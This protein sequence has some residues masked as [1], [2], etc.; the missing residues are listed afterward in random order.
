MGWGVSAA[1]NRVISPAAPLAAAREQASS[2]PSRTDMAA[3]GQ[4]KIA[5][6]N[7]LVG[8]RPV[9]PTSGKPNFTQP[10]SIPPAMALVDPRGPVE[11][12]DMP[13][14]DGFF[15]GT[16]TSAVQVEGGNIDND[17]TRW[18]KTHKGW[19]APNPGLDHWNRLEQDYAHLQGN[20]HNAHGFT[21]DWA[22]IEPKPGVYDRA[23][24]EHY[25]QELAICRKDGMEPMVTLMQY[26][27]PPWLAAKGGVLAPE[28]PK[29]FAEF[30]R[31]CAEEFGP[32]VTW[33]NTMNEPNT[34][35]AA[36]YLGGIW[37]PGKQNPLTYLRS[38][39]AQLRMHA[40]AA[41]ELHK[42]AKEHNR[43]AKVGIVFIDDKMYSASKWNPLDRIVTKLYDWLA[44][45]AFLDALAGG[46]TVGIFGLGDKIP[47]LKG[48][49]DYFG[50]NFYGRGFGKFDTKGSR[51]PITT[52][53]NP[54]HKGPEP[55]MD[56]DGMYE[57]LLASYNQFHVP[58]MITE[59]GVDVPEPDKENKRGRAIVDTLAAM[60][61]AKADGVPVLG[62]LHWTDWDSPEWADGWTQHYGLFG[63]DPQT[64][65]RWDKPAAATFE[66]I[67]RRNAIPQEWLSAEDLQSP[68]L[69]DRHGAHE[70]QVLRDSKH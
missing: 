12:G 15:I 64:G 33:W 4:P 69:R 24:I 1:V 59:N 5:A 61:H 43:V 52:K 46:K 45:R 66:A 41:A 38:L 42:V 26:A 49:L 27:M 65:R 37:S 68:A 22:R 70:L 23:A 8:P 55:V 44:N 17:I 2:A 16:T 34:L 20:G 36:A 56:A 29:K 18:A 21:V 28:A 19:A 11:A 62:Y 40:A 47:G 7:K 50:L 6:R 51:G 32:Q 67:A 3:P 39:N 54:D 30:A 25:K 63:F 14:G 31:V 9:A 10:N 13:L 53:P 57:R 35:S 58:V 60:S 48:S